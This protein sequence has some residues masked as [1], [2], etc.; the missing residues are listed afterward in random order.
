M[1]SYSFL[2]LAVMFSPN[3]FFF[4]LFPFVFI[5]FHF[6]LSFLS[7]ILP[8]SSLP[9]PQ[10]NRTADFWSGLTAYSRTLVK[11]Q[12]ASHIPLILFPTFIIKD[13]QSSL[14][15]TDSFSVNF[16]ISLVRTFFFFFFCIKFTNFWQPQFIS[17][18][19]CCK[20]SGNCQRWHCCLMPALNSSNTKQL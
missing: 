6:S 19:S 1:Y 20:S 11:L 7:Y 10:A 17:L 16:H 13:Y 9:V 18:L 8:F 12:N 14:V 4:F 15:V 2:M 5:L 3:C